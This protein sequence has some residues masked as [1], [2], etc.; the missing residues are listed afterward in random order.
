MTTKTYTSG[1]LFGGAVPS[2]IKNIFRDKNK[3]CEVCG[4]HF[5]KEGICND[6]GLPSKDAFLKAIKQAV[7]KN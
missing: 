4:K 3:Y 6:C 2:D 7:R 5:N 1:E